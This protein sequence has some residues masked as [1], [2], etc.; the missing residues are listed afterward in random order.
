[1]ADRSKQQEQLGAIARYYAQA[2]LWVQGFSYHDDQTHMCTPDYS[3][4]RPALL[5]PREER[6]LF[7]CALVMGDAETVERMTTMFLGRLNKHKLP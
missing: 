7:V 3:C 4:C 5:A 6:E 2:C 1:M